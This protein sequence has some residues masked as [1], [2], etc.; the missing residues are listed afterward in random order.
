MLQGPKYREHRGLQGMALRGFCLDPFLSNCSTHR[1][2]QH[3]VAALV[4]SSIARVWAEAKALRLGLA[5]WC[6]PT[7]GRLKKASS[8]R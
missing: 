2:G 6:W 7:S 4:R 8:Q 5:A 3:A 1:A